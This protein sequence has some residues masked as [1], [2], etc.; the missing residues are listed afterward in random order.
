MKFVK[1][2]LICLLTVMLFY[3]SWPPNSL[4]GFI[5]IAFVPVLYLLFNFKPSLCKLSSTYL[6]GLLFCTFF[7][8][9]FL[10]TSWLIYAHWFGGIFASIVNGFLMTLVCLLIYKI[11]VNLGTKQAY[12]AFPASAA[13]YFYSLSTSLSITTLF[14]ESFTTSAP[15]STAA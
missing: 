3:I 13:S 6:F 1:H 5:F 10:L 14:D 7:S 2:I 15:I 8:L 11:K 4:P 12:F 9:N